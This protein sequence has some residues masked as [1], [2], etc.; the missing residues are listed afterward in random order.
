MKMRSDFVTNSSSTAFILIKRTG[1]S[2]EGIRRLMGIQ[3]NS[4]LTP[5]ADVLCERLQ[6]YGRP[7]DEIVREMTERRGGARETDEYVREEFSGE[8]AQKVAAAKAEGVPVEMGWLSSDVDSVESFLC[9]ESFELENNDYYLNA[10]AC[11]W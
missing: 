11:Y 5:I 2:Q 10:V 7:I 3:D 6:Q 9:C 4:P 8:V 1:L